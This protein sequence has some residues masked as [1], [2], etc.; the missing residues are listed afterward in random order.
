MKELL[1]QSFIK[2]G[3]LIAKSNITVIVPKD[4]PSYTHQ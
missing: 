3:E 2:R 1:S 4:A